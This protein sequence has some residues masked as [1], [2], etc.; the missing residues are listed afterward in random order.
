MSTTP[1]T[2][3]QQI[4]WTAIPNGTVPK[5]PNTLQLSVVVSPRLASSSSAETTLSNY[6]DWLPWPANHVSFTVTIGG[7]TIPSSAVKIVRPAVPLPTGV[8]HSELWELLFTPTTPVTPYAFNSSFAGRRVRSYPAYY[9]REFLV[10]TYTDIASTSPTDW[11]TLGQLFGPYAPVPQTAQALEEA[12]SQISSLFPPQGGG[13][14]P[15]ASAPDPQLDLVQAYLYTQPFAPWT[16]P[17]PTAPVPPP[18]EILVPDFHQIVSS[19]SKFPVLLRAFGLVFDLQVTRPSGLAP[20]VAVSVTPTAPTVTA[21][22]ILPAV[23]TTSATFLPAPQPTNPKINEGRL[24]LSDTLPGQPAYAVVE[25]DLDGSV[26]KTVNFVQGITNAQT[27]ASQDTPTTYAVPALRSSGLTLVRTGW[28][29]DFANAQ[30]DQAALNSA[31]EASTPSTPVSLYAEDVT[32]GFRIDVLDET[33]NRWCQLCARVAAGT[34]YGSSAPEGYVIGL[35]AAAKVIPLPTGKA[36]TAGPGPGETGAPFDEGW[37]ELSVTQAPPG[38]PAFPPGSPANDLFVHETMCRWTGWSLVADRPGQHWAE[39]SN[40][41]AQ[42]TYN[43]PNPTTNVALQAA[44]AAA[45]GTL[46]VLRYGRIYRFGARAVD[47]AGNSLVFGSAPT[48]ASLLWA[49]PAL[50]YGRL[51]PVSTPILVP[52]ASRTPGE[53]LMHLVIRSETYETPDSE[54]TPCQRHLVPASVAE[55]MAE[56]H[57]LFD[58][59]GKPNGNLTTYD[60]IAGRAGMTYATPAVVSALGGVEDAAVPGAYNWPRGTNP[61]YYYPAANLEVP[62]LPD[63]LCRGAAWQN[64]PGTAAGSPPVQVPF[65]SSSPWPAIQP[66]ALALN[67]GTTAPEVVNGTGGNVLNVYLPEGSSQTARLSAYV[68]A[69]DLPSMALW[70]WL[71]EQGLQ[72]TTLETDITTGQHWMFTPYQEMTF[73]HAVRTPNPAVFTDPTIAPRLP[74]KTYALFSDTIDVDFAGSSKIDLMA[75]WTTPFDDGVNPVGA[76]LQNGMAH[77]ADLP[78]ALAEPV[79]QSIAVSGVRHDF[80]DTKY[81]AVTY[82]AQTTSRFLEYFQETVT[83]TLNGTTPTVVNGGGLATG[84][85]VVSEAVPPGAPPGP[86]YQVGVDYVEDDVA[87]TV[88]ALAGGAIPAN[89]EVNVRFVAP[90][91]INTSAPATLAVVST[92]R[93]AVPDIAYILPLFSFNTETSN[94][95]ITS[96]RTGNALR[97]YLAR[98]WYSSGDDEQLGVVLWPLWPGTA[99]PPTLTNLVTRAGR[100][101]IW[102]TNVVNPYPTAADFTLA[103]TSVGTI[104]LVEAAG[105]PGAP[106]VDIAVHYV[107]F[108]PT[109]HRLWYADVGIDTSAAQGIDETNEFSYFPFVRLAVVRYQPNSLPGYEV[110]PVAVADIVQ[111]APNRMATLTFPTTTTVTVGLSFDAWPTPWSPGGLLVENTYTATV[112]EQVPGVSDPDLQWVDI[113]D[114]TVPLNPTLSGPWTGTVTLPAARGSRPFRIRIAEL[115]SHQYNPPGGGTPTTASRLVYLDTIELV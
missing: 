59:A 80:G 72:S 102:A 96:T 88:T 2:Y 60:L 85:T 40:T 68:D 44:H 11:P 81:R 15:P 112:Q 77:V 74:G 31:L 45:P 105:L 20:T 23:Q 76:V 78:L 87:G 95:G 71:G 79:P 9:V 43:Q 25:A 8:T 104:S 67:A 98:P 50:R 109:S 30:G 27:M 32:Q 29:A 103:A 73:V 99:P 33:A 56:A 110:S 26:A 17:P 12:E 19:L 53:H 89:G 22:P 24:R 38:L 42:D 5:S 14:I 106:T 49:S 16:Q 46:P 66:L 18:P 111:V 93:P 65:G 28:A 6:P 36:G 92:A 83:V 107:N 61:M 82:T 62:Y 108:E 57:G 64:L 55:E 13:A 48:P 39:L 94:T 86:A 100:D 113:A 75:T 101:P 51:E 1:P 69:T 114:S 35:G 97:V 7:V 37:I 34:V 90:P 63:V 47:L 21:T 4:I 84:A 115:E 54:V 41:P 58:L 91:V 70:E 52:M 3:S 10:D